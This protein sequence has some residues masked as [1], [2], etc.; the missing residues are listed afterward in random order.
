MENEKKKS[1]VQDPFF[2]KDNKTPEWVDKNSGGTFAT[3]VMKGVNGGHDGMPGQNA[4]IVSKTPG[5]SIKKRKKLTAQDYIDGILSGNMTILAR[6]IT[7]IESNSRAHYELAQEVVKA[8]LP[9]SGNSIRVGITGVPGAGKSSFIETLGHKLCESGKKVAVLAID[10]SSTVTGG[11]ILGDKTRMEKLS[12]HEGAFIR[13]SPSAGNLGGVTR[14]SRETVILCEAFG[15]DTILIETVGVGQNET[16]VRSMVDFFL[17][18]MISGA[19]DEL[20][21]IKKG[22]IEIADALLIN[23]ADGNNKIPA[24]LARQEYSKALHYLTPATEGWKPDAYTCSA[25]TGEGV[26]EMWEV[27]ESFRD[28]MKKSGFFDKRR[29]SQR[30]EWVFAMVEQELKSKFYNN[31]I[32]S[33]LIPIVSRDVRNADVTASQA[34]ERLLNSFFNDL[35]DS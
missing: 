5:S 19:G 13:P 21:G 15:F 3:T 24:G 4:H 27:I 33:S 35:V 29:D 9:H 1:K 32:V 2:S 23:K 20:Q 11:S 14:K 12:Q 26:F 16:T 6:A 22:V 7:L 25:H 17:L 30:L 34:A 10:P 31:N 28:K 8:L 18:L